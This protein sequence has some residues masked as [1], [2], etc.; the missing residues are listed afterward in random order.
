MGLWRT[1]MEGLVTVL[2]RSRLWVTV[3][4]PTTHLTLALVCL[5]LNGETP[6]LLLLHIQRYLADV[7][8]P[9]KG[10]SG[11]TVVDVIRP[12]K[13]RVKW[14]Y[15][16]WCHKARERVKW[17]Y[18]SWCHKARE[19]VKRKYRN[20]CHKAR[21]RVK[22]KNFSWRSFNQKSSL[23]VKYSSFAKVTTRPRSVGSSLVT[24][25]QLSKA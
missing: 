9:G 4:L 11:S 6:G 23:S 16:S 1:F 24:P 13:E 19:W 5:W 8:R 22:S 3:S 12:G 2:C 20:W 18:R 7:T 21:E 15:H 25:A 10:L 17:K 14:K